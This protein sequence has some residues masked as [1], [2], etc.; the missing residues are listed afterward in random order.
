MRIARNMTTNTELVVRDANTVDGHQVAELSTFPVP[1]LL[2]NQ[3][4][5]HFA[6]GTLFKA[7][8]VMQTR[9]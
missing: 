9:G 2:G 7:P 6:V 5:W 1:K 8:L 3:L 4:Y